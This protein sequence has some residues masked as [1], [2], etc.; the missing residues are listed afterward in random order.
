MGKKM[1]S[2]SESVAMKSFF[3]LFLPTAI[4]HKRTT[5]N[6]MNWP[7]WCPELSKRI[8]YL[9]LRSSESFASFSSSSFRNQFFFFSSFDA[10]VY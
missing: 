9:F 1:M 4:Q 5:A 7:T 10:G 3:S 6:Q 8:V 2:V